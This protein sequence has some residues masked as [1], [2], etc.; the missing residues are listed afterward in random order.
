MCD[1]NWGVDHS[2]EHA[3][4]TALQQ[5]A[6]PAA[7]VKHGAQEETRC[8]QESSEKEVG[9]AGATQTPHSS[10]DLPA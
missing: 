4:H 10:S 1:S 7:A 8:A 6:M 5:E 3:K 2:A 9:G